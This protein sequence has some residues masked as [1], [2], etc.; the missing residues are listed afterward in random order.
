L[1]GVQLTAQDKV[2]WIAQLSSLA[3]C[4][5]QSGGPYFLQGG[6]EQYE[7]PPASQYDVYPGNSPAMLKDAFIYGA[8]ALMLI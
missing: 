8:D 6:E 5:R 3:D 2:L 1:Q 7:K 4:L